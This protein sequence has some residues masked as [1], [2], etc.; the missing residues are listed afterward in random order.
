MISIAKPIKNI[1]SYWK[2]IKINKTMI[3]IENRK[4]HAETTSNNVAATDAYE[5]ENRTYNNKHN[6]ETVIEHTQVCTCKDR[7][8]CKEIVSRMERKQ[9]TPCSSVIESRQ[10]CNV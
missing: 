8:Y 6:S 2:I 9:G 3:F 10:H 7:K 1:D 4:T 5:Q